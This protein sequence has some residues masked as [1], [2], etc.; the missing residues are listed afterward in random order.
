MLFPD[1]WMA[2]LP[3]GELGASVQRPVVKDV[4]DVRDSVRL[5]NLTLEERHAHSRNLV[6]QLK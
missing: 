3:N 6:T 2:S 1:Q 4:K 5:P